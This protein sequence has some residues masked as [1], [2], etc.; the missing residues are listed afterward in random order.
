MRLDRRK[1]LTATQQFINLRGN[2][3]CAGDG[4][5]R[6]GRLIWRYQTSPTPLSREYSVRIEYRHG[7]MPDVFIDEPDL[8][9]LA[10]GRK[11]PHVYKQKPTKLCLYLPRTG[12]WRSFMRI[13][14]TVVPWAAL[15]L[16][17]FEEWLASNAWKGGGEH[18]AKPRA[19]SSGGSGTKQKP[20]SASRHQ[21]RY[22]RDFAE[23]DL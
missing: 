12:E 7:G 4:T 11:L 6:A 20:A 5:L 17:Y 14:Q 19:R 13:D 15:W 18:P 23:V 16:F 3:V 9:I 2:P 1:P 22:P 21:R 8:T 10:D